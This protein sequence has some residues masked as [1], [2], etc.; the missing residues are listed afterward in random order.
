MRVFG[1]ALISVE[2]WVKTNLTSTHVKWI[3][4]KIN[5]WMLNFEYENYLFYGP[6][7]H[8]RHFY[9]DYFSKTVTDCEAKTWNRAK[10]LETTKCEVRKANFNFIPWTW[11]MLKIS[12][13]RKACPGTSQRFQRVIMSHWYIIFEFVSRNV[14]EKNWVSRRHCSFFIHKWYAKRRSWAINDSL[15]TASSNRQYSS[16]EEV[17]LTHFFEFAKSPYYDI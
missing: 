8:T 7:L 13:L 2:R 12:P 3:F 11:F 9:K 14:N 1:L 16:V 17:R 4:M 15:E 10:K 5:T 6:R